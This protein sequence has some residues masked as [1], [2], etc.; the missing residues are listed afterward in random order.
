MKPIA[1][2]TASRKIARAVSAASRAAAAMAVITTAAL[3]GAAFS[4]KPAAALDLEKMLQDR[5]FGDRGDDARGRLRAPVQYQR[6]ITGQ[7]KILTNDTLSINGQR[8]V[9]WGL[10]GLNI[11]QECVSRNDVRFKC[12]ERAGL[13][14][15]QRFEGR[16]LQCGIVAEGRYAHLGWCTT[17]DRGQ[18]VDVGGWV[19]SSGFAF[20]CPS[21]SRGYYANPERAAKSGD[22]GVWSTAGFEYPWRYQREGDA[23]G[24]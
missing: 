24:R 1:C 17:A 8:I 14:F 16:T 5:I 7:A 12:G 11:N 20:D 21:Q 22:R 19:V 10:R 3:S 23:C 2:K 13:E 6:E 9:L 4:A 15:A 18:P